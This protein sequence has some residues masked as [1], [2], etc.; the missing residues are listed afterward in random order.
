MGKGP[1]VQIMGNYLNGV[2]VKER[3]E[4]KLLPRFKI[5]KTQMKLEGS[6]CL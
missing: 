4:S 2:K 6:C 3:R 5:L 1:I